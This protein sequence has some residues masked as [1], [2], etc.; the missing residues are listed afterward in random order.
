MGAR[1]EASVDVLGDPY[2][3]RLDGQLENAVPGALGQVVQAIPPP[4]GKTVVIDLRQ[5]SRLGGRG[6]AALATLVGGLEERGHEVRVQPK[7][8]RQERAILAFGADVAEPEDPGGAARRDLVERLGERTLNLGEGAIRYVHVLRLS[9]WHLCLQTFGRAKG[10]WDLTQTA[11]VRM[12]VT[13][14]P[15]VSL[16]SFLIGFIL[17][18]QAAPLLRR[19]GQ[20]ILVADLVGMAMVM[21]IGPL[22]TAVLVAGR[23]GSSLTA[24]IGTMAVSEEID[25]L[26]VMGVSPI[27]Y[28][29][30]PRLRGMLLVLPALAMIADLMGILGGLTVATTVFGLSPNVYIDE[31]LRALVPGDVLGGLLKSFFFAMVIV[32]VAAHQGFATSGSAAGVGRNTTR[33]VVQA[34]I[35]IIVVDAI[36]TWILFVLRS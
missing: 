33:S 4:D 20:E 32:S 7:D 6:V 36:F 25:A 23:S 29:V 11:V 27:G 15:L 12:G 17:A 8:P 28:L 26:E 16:I 14:T 18:L 9:L 10:R 35:W 13:A 1:L 31:T 19:Y 24:E 22:L 2:V 30:A 34:I 3:V 5:V 21:E